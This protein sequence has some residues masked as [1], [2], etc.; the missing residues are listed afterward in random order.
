MAMEFESCRQI[1]ETLSLK[2]SA[3][4]NILASFIS[5]FS[6]LDRNWTTSLGVGCGYPGEDEDGS[7]QPRAE[8]YPIGSRVRY[9]CK[10]GTI[11]FPAESDVRTCSNK[12]QWKMHVPRCVPGKLKNLKLWGPS[13]PSL[14]FDREKCNSR[15]SRRRSQTLFERILV[16]FI[17]KRITDFESEHSNTSNFHRVKRF[18]FDLII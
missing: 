12:G 14:L 17:S 1:P 11:L 6:N 2:K 15:T 10:P 8:F 18:W 3:S 13:K 5:L 7:F 16:S 9:A 4:T